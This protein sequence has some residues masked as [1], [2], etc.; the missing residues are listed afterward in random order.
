MIRWEVC[1]VA[2]EG[3]KGSA[4]NEVFE[5]IEASQIFWQDF[6]E[7][8]ER[9]RR[10]SLDG[11]ELLRDARQKWSFLKVCVRS[12]RGPCRLLQFMGGLALATPVIVMESASGGRQVSRLT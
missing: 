6:G 3:A 4:D 7:N 8:V 2:L 1:K 10:V 12:Q 9:E 11:R 5:V